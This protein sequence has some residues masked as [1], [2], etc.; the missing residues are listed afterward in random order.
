MVNPIDLALTKRRNPLQPFRKQ[1]SSLKRNIELGNALW[2][3]LMIP[4][5]IDLDSITL[6]T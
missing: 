3:Q 5:Q 2:D 4:F 6:D 1:H